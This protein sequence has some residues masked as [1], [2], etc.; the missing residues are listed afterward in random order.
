MG[1]RET[2]RENTGR[3]KREKTR[4]PKT[5]KEGD[6]EMQRQCKKRRPEREMGRVS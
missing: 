5:R 3:A 6:E 4:E 1:K 2:G